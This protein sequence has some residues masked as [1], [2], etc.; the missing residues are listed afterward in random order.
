MIIISPS[1]VLTADAQNSPCIGSDNRVLT[2]NIISDSANAA[3]P[4]TNVANPATNILWKSASLAAQTITIDNT[5][6]TDLMD[7][8]AIARHNFGSTRCYVRLDVTDFS[9]STTTVIASYQPADDK[10]LIFRFAPQQVK[11]FKIYLIPTSATVYP[12][13]AVIYAGKL[14]VSPRNVYVGHTPLT[15]GRQTQVSNGKSENGNFLGRIVIQESLMTGLSLMN[16]N[17]AWY[18]SVFDP[19][20]VQA[21]EYPFFFAWRPTTYP[22]EVGYAWMTGD[23][24]PSN[25]RPNGMMQVD[26]QMTGVAS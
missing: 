16:L 14:V 7:Y 6:N 11:T 9:A 19:F 10:A 8:L 21:K 5:A 26:L 13:A 4:I 17:A 22:N 24:K 2:T 3:Y 12:Q 20:V 23:P 15:L 25:Q 18:R 1:L